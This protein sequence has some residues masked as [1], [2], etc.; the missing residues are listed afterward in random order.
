MEVYTDY[1][2]G[3]FIIHSFRNKRETFY[4]SEKLLAKMRNKSFQFLHIFLWQEGQTTLQGK[5]IMLFQKK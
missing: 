1:P 4:F 2:Q 5:D 3:L